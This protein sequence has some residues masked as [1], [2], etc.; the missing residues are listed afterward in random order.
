MY[1]IPYGH[2][3]SDRVFFIISTVIYC[4]LVVYY[5]FIREIK[6]YQL[7]KKTTYEITVDEIIFHHNFLGLKRSKKIP[8][9]NI[10][11]FHLVKFQ[12]GDIKKGSIFI[13]TKT[14]VRTYDIGERERN[15]IPKIERITEYNQVCNTLISL[16]KRHNASNTNTIKL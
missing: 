12:V 13:Y 16:L 3:I 15:T 6:Y 14:E 4:S 2:F 8:F 7:A 10:K 9:S 5:L 1:L 11:L